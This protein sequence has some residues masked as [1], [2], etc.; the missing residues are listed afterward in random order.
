MM[1]QLLAAGADANGKNN[2]DATALMWCSNNL[3]K[4]RLLID[5]GANVNAQSKQGQRPLSIAAAHDGAA[6]VIRLLLQKGADAKA[7]AGG[8]STALIVAAG[9][10]DI[11]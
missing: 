1:R 9:A 6:D 11:A 4:V 5:K 10:N 2:F 3:E 7:P 8:A